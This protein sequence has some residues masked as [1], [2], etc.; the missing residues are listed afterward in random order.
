MHPKPDA[1]HPSSLSLEAEGSANRLPLPQGEGR[2]EGDNAVIE[3]E[4]IQIRGGNNGI[5]HI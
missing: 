2:G 3:N 4:L 1:K 5:R